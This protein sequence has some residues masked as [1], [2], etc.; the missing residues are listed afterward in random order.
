MTSRQLRTDLPESNA[1]PQPAAG[2]VVVFRSRDGNWYEKD[3]Q[4][5]TRQLPW[6]VADLLNDLAGG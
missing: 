3:D 5:V 1:V 2:D 6:P 4:G